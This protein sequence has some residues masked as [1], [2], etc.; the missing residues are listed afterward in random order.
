MIDLVLSTHFL[1][2]EHV[3]AVRGHDQHA[4]LPNVVGGSLF[5]QGCEKHGLIRIRELLRHGVSNDVDHLSSFKSFIY[6]PN[7]FH[8]CK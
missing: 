1:V 6:Y 5:G 4:R 8:F 2:F 7:R 3:D